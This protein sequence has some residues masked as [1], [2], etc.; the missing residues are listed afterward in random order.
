MSTE[1]IPIKRQPPRELA[2]A[3]ELPS[4]VLNAGGNARYAYAEFFGDQV[5]NEHTRKVYRH[6][7]DRFLRWCQEQAYELQR[8]PPGSVGQYIRTLKTTNGKPTSKPTQKLHLAAIRKFFDTLVV[9]HAV[10]INLIFLHS[11]R[12]KEE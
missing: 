6:A 10:V 4:I 8:I 1:I 2:G 12:L 3:G 7:V 11:W 9:R 5:E